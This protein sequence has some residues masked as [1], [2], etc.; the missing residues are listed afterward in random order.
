MNGIYEKFYSIFEDM[1]KINNTKNKII[2]K[3]K[4]KKLVRKITDVV[5]NDYSSNIIKTIL[6]FNNIIK[7]KGIECYIPNKYGFHP[8]MHTVVFTPRTDEIY[9]IEYSISN[10]TFSISQYRFYF[11]INDTN[12]TNNKLRARWEEIDKK[13]IKEILINTILDIGQFADLITHC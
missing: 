7:S 5:N 9:E 3:Y 4:Y 2:R 6:D 11:T 1:D 13:Y 10:N 8:R 12:I